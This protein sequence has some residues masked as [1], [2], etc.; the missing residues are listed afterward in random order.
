M[1]TDELLR[2]LQQPPQINTSA[3]V[4]PNATAIGDVIVH[5]DAS[6]WFGAVLRGDTDT[7]SVGARTNIQDNAVIHADPGAPCTIGSDCVIGHT[8][9]VHGATLSHHVLIGMH[10]T[11][12]NHAQIG[13]YSIIGANAMVPQGMI[14]PPYS[15]VLGTPAKV[16]KTLG[17]EV[18]SQIQNNVDEYV[19]RAK[20][21]KKHFAE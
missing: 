2:K 21:Y 1:T 14:I 9:I 17:P 20:V 8:A 10:A 15:L 7:I 18:E 12:L 4:A 16:V 19:L 3:F 13:E 6:L 5:E 11:V